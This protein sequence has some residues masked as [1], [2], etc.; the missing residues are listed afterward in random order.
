MLQVVGT[1][2]HGV[3]RK[4]RSR[5]LRIEACLHLHREQIQVD[6]DNTRPSQ[7]PGCVRVRSKVGGRGRTVPNKHE[8]LG[9]G[10]VC[11]CERSLPMVEC[12]GLEMLPLLLVALVGSEVLACVMTK[13]ARLDGSQLQ[14]V[15]VIGDEG[16]KRKSAVRCDHMDRAKRGLVQ[17]VVLGERHRMASEVKVQGCSDLICEAWG[18]RDLMVWMRRIDRGKQCEI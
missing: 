5:D 15:V 9:L 12:I 18:I 16:G 2:L 13:V 10:S 8:A 7:D 3:I 11:Q 4:G 14:R 17:V 6:H 1:S